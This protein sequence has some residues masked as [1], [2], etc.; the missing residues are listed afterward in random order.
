MPS[1]LRAAIA[2]AVLVPAAVA[3]ATV[4]AS[5][6]PPEAVVTA[7]SAERVSGPEIAAAA[8]ATS[9]G[10]AR[11]AVGQHVAAQ[12]R[13]GR[14]V[15]AKAVKAALVAGGTV[16]WEGGSTVDELRVGRAEVSAGGEQGETVE[17]ALIGGEDEQ[18]QAAQPGSLVGAGMT[19]SSSFSG[20]TRLANYCQTW[21]ASGNSVTACVEKF[22]P[23]NDGSSTRDYYAYNRWGTAQ[24]KV[25]DWAPDYKV[26]KFDMR[27]RPRA[28]YASRTVGMNDYFPND[29]SQLCA[30]GGSASV[31][32]GSLSVTIGLT[33][34]SEKYPVPNATTK[35]MGL[36]YD[37]GAV[38]E[39]RTKGVDYEQEVFS[40]QGDPSPSLGFYNYGKFCQGTYLTCNGT[41]GLD[42][43]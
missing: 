28:G 30:E 34:C 38:F 22:D 39:S 31:G 16:T 26:T 24:G 35:T 12:A 15:D 37:A 43:W 2:A 17:L 4:P 18:G 29:A 41:T 7:R 11:A 33:N 8:R 19:G 27:S 14:L 3:A 36:V 23:S 25:V 10:A 6:A 20:G 1:C 42:G 9:P 21:T 32:V 40:W 13:A 5:A